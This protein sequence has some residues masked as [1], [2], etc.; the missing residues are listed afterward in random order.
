LTY[1]DSSTSHND[2]R[3][4]NKV[5]RNVSYLR[6]FTNSR[7]TNPL[8]RVTPRELIKQGQ[9]FDYDKEKYREMLLEAAE[10]VLGFLVLTG[11]FMEM[12]QKGKAESGGLDL[13][14]SGK[15]TLKRSQ[16]AVRINLKSPLVAALNLWW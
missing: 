5:H 3:L 2:S 11:S 15:E 13:G 4:V 6:L 7:H 9:E 1:A 12:P 10:T 16:S 14:R 8:R